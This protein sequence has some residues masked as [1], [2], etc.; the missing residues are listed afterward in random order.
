MFFL[1]T[2]DLNQEKSHERKSRQESILL[3]TVAVYHLHGHGGHK[4]SRTTFEYKSTDGLVL[5]KC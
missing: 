1:Q 5:R 3:L 2:D 4:H